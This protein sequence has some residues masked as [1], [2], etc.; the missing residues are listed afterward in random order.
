MVL[1]NFNYTT[2]VFTYLYLDF[3]T[4]FKFSETD[5]LLCKFVK[6][7]EIQFIKTVHKKIQH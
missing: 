2:L 6:K 7:I 5:K 1:N 4:N 3:L